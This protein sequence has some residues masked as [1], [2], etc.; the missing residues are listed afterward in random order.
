[1]AHHQ[2]TSEDGG[3]GCL[4]CALHL[5]DEATVLAHRGPHQLSAL[6][7]I[8][9]ISQVECHLQDGHGHHFVPGPGAIT[10][11]WCHLNID[12]HTP[13]GISPTCPRDEDTP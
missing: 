11:A 3:V 9:L 4:I 7:A 10:C 5:D 1:M 12:R 2:I 13:G 6:T 8:N